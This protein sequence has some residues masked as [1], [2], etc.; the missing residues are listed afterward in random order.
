MAAP[1]ADD[2]LT[3]IQQQV[4]RWPPEAFF[5][6]RARRDGAARV[7][8]PRA[9]LYARLSEMHDCGLLGR[10]F[11]EFQAISAAS[12]ATSTTSTPSTSTPC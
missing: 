4:D 11:P 8:R 12:F 2:T 6:T 3:W 5:P 7:S 1:V 9:G 10:M